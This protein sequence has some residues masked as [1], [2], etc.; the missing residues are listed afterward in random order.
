MLF[1]GSP[2]QQPGVIY[3]QCLEG[4]RACPPEDVGRIGGYGEYLEAIADSSHERHEEL[5]NWNGPFDPDKFNAR[6]TTHVMQEGMPD[7]RQMD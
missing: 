1:E 7:W 6:L 5:L 4:A 2:P 3:P